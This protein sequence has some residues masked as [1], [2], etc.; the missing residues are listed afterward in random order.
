VDVVLCVSMT[1]RLAIT[2]RA[3]ASV[4]NL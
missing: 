3:T 1:I 4:D 2:L